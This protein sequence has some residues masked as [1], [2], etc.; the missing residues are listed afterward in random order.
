MAKAA[1]GKL[2][3]R[4]EDIDQTRCTPNLAAAVMADLDWLQIKFE[5]EVRFQSQH[6][7]DYHAALEKL[8]VM[9]L[10]YPCS[11]TRADLAAN[12]GATNDP[13]GQPQYAGTCLKQG[14]KPGAPVAWRMNMA[15][16]MA[17]V[18]PLT[19]I[20]NGAI[21]PAQPH[22]WGDVV[23][24]RKD[25]GVSYHI[26]VV[27]DDALQGVTDVVR[28]QDLYHATSIHRLLQTLLNLPE[29]RY[30]HH[31]LQRTDVGEKLSKSKGHESLAML[32]SRG[33]TADDIRT[34][35]AV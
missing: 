16:A 22:H 2:L 32:R 18:D 4:I 25:I 19:W 31:G 1:H 35:L 20:E 3:L 6:M 28:G 11:C 7:A 5:P 27:I 13:E 8:R 34:L 10:L 15:K 23:L 26:A 17:P 12:P 24:G 9:D 29:P 30:F 21:V 14:P 33:M